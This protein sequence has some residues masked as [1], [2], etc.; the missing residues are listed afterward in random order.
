MDIVG[1]PECPNGMKAD[2][3]DLSLFGD[4]Q[5]GAVYVGHVFECVPGNLEM[6]IA[7][8][9]RVAE[10][11]FVAHLPVKSASARGLNESTNLIYSAPP[12]TPFVAW[13]PLNGKAKFVTTPTRTFLLAS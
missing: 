2:V 4:K 11:M 10:E 12:T 1:C 9:Y 3:R 8:V 6:G 13:G 5:F 7:E